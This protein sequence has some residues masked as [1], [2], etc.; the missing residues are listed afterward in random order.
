MRNIELDRESAIRC[1][2]AHLATLLPFRDRHRVMRLDWRKLLQP[3]RF[4]VMAKTIYAR[5]H[6]SGTGNDWANELYRAHLEVWSGFVEGDGSGKDSYAKYRR[7]FDAVIEGIA[8]RGFDPEHSLLP[9]DVDGVIIDGA[10]RAAACIAL[11]QDAW[12]IPFEY[13]MD[14]YGAERFRQMGLSSIYLDA[15]AVEYARLD[16]DS[17]LVC[18][19][20]AALDKQEVVERLLVEYGSIVYRKP[21]S[22]TGYGPQN[23]I[24]QLYRDE[25]WLGRRQEGWPGSRS[26]VEARFVDGK[27]VWFYLLSCREPQRMRQLKERI[28][29]ACGIGNYAVHI[30]DTA[31]E[32]FR[33]C[34][35]VFNAGSVNLFSNGDLSFSGRTLALQDQF[36]YELR[37]RQWDPENFCVDGSSVMALYGLR[38]GND[39]DYLSLDGS[40]TF[41][42]PLINCHTDHA[43]HHAYSVERL[44]TDPRLFLRYDGIKYITLD[45]LEQM[46]LARGEGKD[47]RDVAMIE[48]LKAGVRDRSNG[49]V[50]PLPGSASRKARFKSWVKKHVAAE[51]RAVANTSLERF[52]NGL[53]TLRRLPDYIKGS[54]KLRYRGF[55][56]RY[57]AGDALIDRVRGGHLYEPE[58]TRAL[59]RLLQSI[60]REAIVLDIGANIGLVSLNI[61]SFMPSTRIH[62]F[63]PGPRTAAYLRETLSLNDLH[64]RITLHPF[65]L[66]NFTGVHPFSIHGRRHN[67]GDGFS[68]TGRTRGSR[69][70]LVQTIT[71][72]D[73]WLANECPQVKVIKLDTEGSELWVLEG[74]R[75]LIRKL[76]PAIVLEINVINLEAYDHGPEAIE[77]FFEEYQYALT[78]LAGTLVSRGELAGFLAV[79][80]DFIAVPAGNQGER[81]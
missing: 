5:S 80:N 29:V 36:K 3:G 57:G 31:E 21:L 11:K 69:S 18:L 4:D 28:R 67:S 47:V 32:T 34:G 54:P 71:L 75:Q 10:H 25:S 24:A 15:M 6:L 43:G 27:P 52:V 78:T 73:W 62:A 58:V 38:E 1:L 66:S 56:V 60:E 35:Q 68:D 8:V 26:H 45:V 49:E 13:R 74:G 63:E 37:R 14:D 55:R 7:A 72:D 53:R 76:R 51:I 79:A 59:I 81:A 16:R 33:L 48:G 70:I 9:V 42:E 50:R 46:K 61:L 30:N 40:P 44:I 64:E 77:R 12:V 39:Y 19:F 41:T 22:L 23:L 20:P 17:R 65:A 2:N